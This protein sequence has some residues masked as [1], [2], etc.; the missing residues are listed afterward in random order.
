MSDQEPKSA[1][2]LAMERLRKKDR[3]EEIKERPITD[4]Q[5]SAIAEVKNV[6][7]AKLAEREIFHKDAL[8]KAADAD[9]VAVLDEE[10]RRD[11]ERLTSDR[12][13][14]NRRD[15]EVILSE[16]G[17]AASHP[18]EPPLSRGSESRSLGPLRLHPLA[19]QG[20]DAM[21]LAAKRRIWLPS[22]A[23]TTRSFGA[24]TTTDAPQ[25]DVRQP[26]LDDGA[27]GDDAVLG[28]EHDAFADEVAVAVLLLDA[29]PR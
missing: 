20:H 21:S 14:K 27:V 25:D 7:E 22:T 26:A 19:K 16:Q 12:D 15:P 29:R 9:A 13:R 2:E 6:C 10:Y 28:D 18:L 23:S 11:R 24:T 1:L 5:R 4:E 3:E 17:G 8:R